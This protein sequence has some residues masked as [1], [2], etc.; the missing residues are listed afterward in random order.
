M[1]TSGAR[2]ERRLFCVARIVSAG[3][4]DDDSGDVVFL[5]IDVNG[6]NDVFLGNGAGNA[7]SLFV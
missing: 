7:V 2:K 1:K 5:V 4:G 3:D 6:R